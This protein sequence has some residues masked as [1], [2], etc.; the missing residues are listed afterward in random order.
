M[1]NCGREG[2]VPPP[3]IDPTG[4]NRNLLP[5][6]E[7]HYRYD[8]DKL[9]RELRTR[10][11]RQNEARD[12]AWADFR[13]HSSKF[14]YDDLMQFVPRAE[15]REGRRPAFAVGIVYRDQRNG[16]RPAFSLRNRCSLRAQKCR[17]EIAARRHSACTA[18]RGPASIILA[19]RCPGVV[20]R[21]LL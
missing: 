4:K 8:L 12:A 3:G 10:L 6:G 17:Y 20:R 21:A 19:S 13:E 2:E 14:T 18:A 9:Q 1:W 11:V 15:R 5:L 7:F 16:A